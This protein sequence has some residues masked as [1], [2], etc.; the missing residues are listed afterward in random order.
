DITIVFDDE[1]ATQIQTHAVLLMLASPVFNSML[2]HSMKEKTSRQI[3][4]PGK[5]PE[6]FKVLLQ[7]LQPVAGRVQ[8]ISNENVDFL[9]RWC[10]EYGISSLLTECMEFV[11]SQPPSMQ[12]ILFAYRYG[13]NKYLESCVDSLLRSGTKDFTPCY[14]FPELVQKV[15]ERSLC[16]FAAAVSAGHTHKGGRLDF[17]QQLECCKCRRSCSHG[18]QCDQCKYK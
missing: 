15:L 14:D 1:A 7:F 2:T 5:N 6:E 12:G 8:K 4:L 16:C 3:K 18:W 10:E 9:A 11:K 17:D 13:E